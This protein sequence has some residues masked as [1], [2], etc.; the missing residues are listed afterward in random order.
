MKITVLSFVF[1]F[2]TLLIA[3]QEKKAW[4]PWESIIGLTYYDVQ[5]IR[6]MQNRI[7]VFDDGTIGAVWNAN[8]E[9]PPWSAMGIGYN[10]FDGTSWGSPPYQTVFGG[11]P[12][13][14]SY[15]D[16]NINGE[17]IAC[18]DNN[19]I[20]LGT[21]ENHGTGNW[22]V[23]PLNNSGGKHPVIVTT[24]P[25]N[26]ILHLLF[27]NPDPTAPPTEPQPCRGFIQ[28][29]HSPDGGISWNILPFDGLGP[30]QYLGFT[31]GSYVWAEPKDDN[32]L[33]FVA[34][35]YL[36]DLVL[37]K[38]NDGGN[39]WQK[40][41]I[42]QHPYPFMEIFSFDS[43]TFYCNDG[44]I[45]VA[46]DNEFNAHVAFGI[47]RVYSSTSQDSIW[48]CPYV[49]AIAY[50][51]EGM[52]AFSNN[53]NALNPYGVSGSELIIDYNLIG[54]FQDINGNGQIDTMGM[55]GIYHTPGC[56]TMPQL[57]CTSD[58]FLVFIYSGTSET[59]NNGLLDYKHLWCRIG[60]NNGTNWGAF[61]DLD[62]DLIHIF[63]ECVYPSVAPNN[64]EGI[65]LVYQTD[66]DPG[67]CEQET[68]FNENQ[69]RH[70]FFEIEWTPEYLTPG[71]NASAT[72]VQEGGS[73]QFYNT[74]TG[75]PEP[76]YFEWTFE[77]GTPESSN[78]ENPVV[79][80]NAQGTYD[81]TL[82]VSNG[83]M[84]QTLIK[85]DYITVLP[86]TGINQVL[87]LE[88]MILP[89]PTTGKLSV[90]IP[91]EENH[92]VTVISLLG[93]TVYNGHAEAGTI[94]VDIDLS[95]QA[96]GIYFV[97][98]KSESKNTIRKIVLRK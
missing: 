25:N 61:V 42:W 87:S 96:E 60:L 43:D 37:M 6:A 12:I 86:E 17:I 69:I 44:G 80:Y 18:Q 34:G 95:N 56:L 50:W 38:S 35:D 84:N 83:V 98:V 39:S 79:V 20:V 47:S 55:G 67:L 29:A 63:D 85:E 33:A 19:G 54:Y 75:Y 89:N 72:L 93:K 11:N 26:S 71:F 5:S 2:L 70:M 4:P 3:G 30:D 48:Y 21:R 16:F 66:L 91:E 49:G 23:Y 52:P 15:T 28:Y 81:V 68:C 59:Y 77:G 45:T 13:N 32:V 97:L 76:D 51:N 88:N 7:F 36:T 27:L 24:G 65:N 90:I 31:V 82:Y 10:F 58:N 73:V 57:I 40:T 14:P 22:Q 8:F 92:D 9:A 1:L 94:R 74:S 46:L 64:F 78:L 41:V 53:I 62:S